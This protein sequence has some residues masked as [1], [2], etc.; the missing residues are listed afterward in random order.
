MRIERIPRRAS[1]AARMVPEAPP[2]TIATAAG[3]SDLIV[4]PILRIGRPGFAGLD[5]IVDSGHRPA[6]GFAEPTRDHRVHH[7]RT[8]GA[9]ELRADLDRAPPMATPG[10]AER[11]WMLD[12]QPVDRS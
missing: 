7:R 8:A 4:R 3:R 12:E 1:C 2:P 10:H 5:M 11:S 9:D 6:G